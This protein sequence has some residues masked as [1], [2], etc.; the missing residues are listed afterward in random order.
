MACFGPDGSHHQDGMIVGDADWSAVDFVLWRSSIGTRTDRTFRQWCDAAMSRGKAFCAYHFVYRTTAPAGAAYRAHPAEAQADTVELALGGDKSIPVMLDWESDGA[1]VPTFDDVLL[2]AAALRARGYRVP[3]LYTGRWYWSGYAG[4]PTLAGHGFE[5]VNS[6]YG[7]QRGTDTHEI[8]SRYA[9]LGGDASTRWSA[10]YGGLDPVI[11]QFGSRVRWGN[12]YMDMNAHRAPVAELGRLFWTPPPPPPP[13]PLPPTEV[14]EVIT[15]DE[16]QMIAGE[17]WSRMLTTDPSGVAWPADQMLGW[18]RRD[19]VS[20]RMGLL[21]D[22]RLDE[23]AAKVASKVG[24]TASVA[25]IAKA[26]VAALAADLA[27]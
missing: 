12:R 21:A 7:D 1:Q 17:V 2:V 18:L 4:R 20:L 23:L 9:E 5:L 15:R 6:N 27:D 8:L 25:D 16:A 24:S 26:V 3:L 10:G 19:V 22:A 13:P 11:W 14:D